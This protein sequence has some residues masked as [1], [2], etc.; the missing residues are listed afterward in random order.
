MK[1]INVDDIK[2]QKGVFVNPMT[3]EPLP[4]I[5]KMATIEMLRDWQEEVKA[6]PPDKVK[7]AR[8]EIQKLRGCSCS[9]SDGIIDDVEDILDKLIESEG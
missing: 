1:L 9:C 5:H 2:W 7:Q 3:D 6:I 4:T 8:E